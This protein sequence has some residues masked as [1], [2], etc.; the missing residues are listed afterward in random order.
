MTIEVSESGNDVLFT[1][2]GTVD[3]SA[4]TASNGR[5]GRNPDDTFK[6]SSFGIRSVGNDR[7][8]FGA[9]RSTVPP[10]TDL[11]T[12]SNTQTLR[13]VSGDEAY[14]LSS[15][16]TWWNN[17]TAGQVNNVSFVYKIENQTISN[18]GVSYGTLFTGENSN[19]A[20]LTVNLAE[21]GANNSA[22]VPV[23]GTLLL[24]TAGILGGGI[25][26]RLAQ[27]PV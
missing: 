24:V 16:N 4:F 19:G 6:N 26:R 1:G 14:F 21:P 20:S 11:F 25:T 10:F 18:L 27:P 15:G 2:S 7:Y 23:P 22:S 8:Y 12:T 13:R 5:L 3:L 9:N 17:V